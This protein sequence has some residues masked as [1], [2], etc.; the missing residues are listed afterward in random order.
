MD[1][2]K[3]GVL[4]LPRSFAVCGVP[5]G[6]DYKP[7]A[8]ACH[9]CHA[10]AAAAGSPCQTRQH[11]SPPGSLASPS[12]SAS[13]PP[14][15]IASPIL[16][17]PP[18]PLA[19]NRDRGGQIDNI[20]AKPSKK[21]M[22]SKRRLEQSAE[23]MVPGIPRHLLDAPWPTNP[24]HATSTRV[25]NR[26]GIVYMRKYIHTVKHTYTY[27]QRYVCMHACVHA[28]MHTCIYVCMFVCLCV[29]VC[30]YMYVS[31]YVGR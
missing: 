27:A 13:S 21:Q 5:P 7:L 3:Q 20:L 8:P 26:A 2:S 29:Y 31:T 9:S 16:P 30:V 11:S 18:S 17:C 4:A 14:H 12:P 24:Q 6:R 19:R 22:P 28:C 10:S 15:N 1:C 23:E 25:N